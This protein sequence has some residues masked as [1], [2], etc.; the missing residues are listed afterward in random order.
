MVRTANGKLYGRK[1]SWPILRHNQS[2]RVE[3]LTQSSR[4]RI[5]L[6][7]RGIHSGSGWAK[8]ETSRGTKQVADPGSHELSA[9][10]VQQ[11]AHSHR[12]WE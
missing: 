11:R 3:G 9:Q 6:G 1:Q 7:T 8:G 10:D 12:E 2:I 5:K 4:P